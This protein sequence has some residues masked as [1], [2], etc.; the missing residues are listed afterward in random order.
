VHYFSADVLVHFF[1]EIRKLLLHHL[2]F[3]LERWGDVA[4]LDCQRLGEQFEPTHSLVMRK[5]LLDSVNLS[6]EKL[7]NRIL[8]DQVSFIGK[9][10]SL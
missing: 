3:D 9:A 2:S 7:A 1:D 8:V 4:I 10:D 6:L 5:I